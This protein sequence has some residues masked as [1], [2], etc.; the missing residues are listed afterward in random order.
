MKFNRF[1]KDGFTLVELLVVIAIIGIL[2]G[3]LL[4]AVQQVREAARRSACQNNMR[5]LALGSL[6]F[7]SAHMHFPT[8]GQHSDGFGANGETGTLTT[9]ENWGWAYQILPFIEQNVLYDLRA[10]NPNAV[11]GQSIALLNCPSRGNRIGATTWGQQFAL[12]DYASMISSWNFHWQYYS[13]DWGGFQ[14]QDVMTDRVREEKNVFR[15]I[16]SKG[17]QTFGDSSTS[18]GRGEQ[19]FTLIGFGHVTDGSSNTIMY[20]E[21][22]VQSTRYSISTAN[23]WDWW[24]L[25]G[26][27]FGADWTTMRG[28][29]ASNIGN[30][31]IWPDGMPAEERRAGSDNNEFAL[32]G[33]H[34][35]TCNVSLGDGS[36]HAVSNTINGDIFDRLG[37]RSDGSIHNPTDQ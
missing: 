14:W 23:G 30:R 26:Q 29:M 24:E 20:G 3:M 15:G 10:S 21:K 18:T 22:S 34:P 6:N 7:E 35:G 1:K 25:Q 33:P 2:I 31:Y 12:G 5:Q 4:P 17:A 16:I 27:M 28:A 37:R 8:A 11:K 19:K 32:G 36:I 13:D 9:R